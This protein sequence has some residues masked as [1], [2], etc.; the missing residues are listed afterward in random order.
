MFTARKGVRKLLYG[1]LLLGSFALFGSFLRL[2]VLQSLQLAEEPSNLHL[3]KPPTAPSIQLK[4]PTAVLINAPTAIPSPTVTSSATTPPTPTSTLA[5]TAT[6]LP[7]PSATIRVTQKPIITTSATLEATSIAITETVTPLPWPTTNPALLIQ[8]PA[9][10]NLSSPHL[11]FSRPVDGNNNPSAPYRFG[12]TYNQRLSPHHGIDI[13]N[14]F[15]TPVLAVGAG[16]VLYAGEDIETL[17]GPKPDFYGRLVVIEIANKWEERTIYTLY[18]HL[19]SVNVTQ[20]QVVNPSDVIGFVGSTGVSLGPHLHFE[21]R[22]DDPYSYDSVRNPELWYRPYS[23]RG[24]LAGRVVDANGAF[25]PGTRVNLACS[26]GTLRFVETYWD[27]FTIPDDLLVENFVI[28]DLPAG[29][30]RVWV[31]LFDNV[32]ENFIEIQPGNLSLV[33]LQ[34]EQ[35]P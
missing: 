24:V 11:W 16:T 25:L 27:Q 20:G 10:L 18:G 13:A 7:S 8:P 2:D 3:I 21:V 32:V 4:T 28:S 26:D 35:S 17:F 1:I 15:G 12:M 6:P 30:C 19:E 33:I 9:E 29:M 22:Q 23:G 5:W 14:D 31:E 34:S